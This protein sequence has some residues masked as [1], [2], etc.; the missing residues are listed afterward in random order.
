MGGRTSRDQS[1]IEKLLA[2]KDSFKN[3]EVG[4]MKPG[5]NKITGTIASSNELADL[6]AMLRQAGIARVA[7]L[8]SVATNVPP[9]EPR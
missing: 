7:I 1:R 5:Y 8:V 9:A 4:L 3:L 6:E 2:S